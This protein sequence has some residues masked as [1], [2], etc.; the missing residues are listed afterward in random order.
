MAYLFAAQR[1]LFPILQKAAQLSSCSQSAMAE[2][3][4]QALSDYTRSWMEKGM[5]WGGWMTAVNEAKA[6]F[7]RLINADACDIAAMS[8]VSDITSSI[9]SALEFK[10]GKNGVVVGD[11]D[12]PSMGHVWLAH[13]RKGA[14]V[15]FVAADA[16]H[17]IGTEAY[18]SAIND[19]TVLVSLAQVYYY[20][21]F[22]QDIAAITEI[23]HQHGALV[24]VDAY[25]SAGSMEI[26]VRGQ[27]IDIL[28]SGA[29]KYLLG[30]P[31][32]ADEQEFRI[33]P[34]RPRRQRRLDLVA[35]I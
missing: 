11:V 22:I 28:A 16:D 6:E 5:D 23:A 1:A 19:A 25:Q 18:R 34:Q 15:R 17:T 12:F 32:I 9:G 33:E 8:C 20:N 10:P 14:A 4:A 7:A 35:Q 29:Q 2:P 30:I 31:G 27:A 24:F 26:D 13:E 3:V 21:G